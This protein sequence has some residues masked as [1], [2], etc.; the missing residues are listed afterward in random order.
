MAQI[1]DGALGE[2]AARAGLLAKWEHADGSSRSVTPDTLRAALRA[3]RLPCDTEEDRRE[4]LKRL[5]VQQE[6]S[7]R[8]LDV[9]DALPQAG[10]LTLETGEIRAAAAGDAIDVPGYHHL[11][12]ADRM[13]LLAVAPAA[14]PGVFHLTESRRAWGPAVQIY[15]LRGSCESGFGDLAALSLF[16]R[17]AA[18]SGAHLAAI[19]PVHALFMADPARCSPYAPS[20]RDMLNPLYA[21]PLEGSEAGSGDLIDWP[22]AAAARIARLEADFAAFGGDP[23]FDW[24]AAD[25]AVADH[26]LFEALSQHFVQQGLSA[27]WSGW[28]APFQHPDDVEVRRFAI[29]HSDAVRFHVYLQWRA[30]EGLRNVQAE[31]RTAGMGIGLVADLAVGLHP[32]GSH[33][34]SRRDELLDGLTIGAPPDIF[35]ADGQ[36]WGITSFSPTALAESGFDPFLR[37]VRKALGFAGGVRVD[38]ALGLERLWLIPQGAEPRDGV[39]LK[40]PFDDLVRLLVLEAHRHRALLIAE[41]LG[42]VPAGFRDRMQARHLLGMRVTTFERDAQGGFVD[43]ADWTPA[44]VAMTSTHDLIPIA[45]WWAGTDIG[46]RERLGRTSE[47]EDDRAADRA[48]FWPDPDRPA[49]DEPEPVVDKAIDD[50]GRAACEIA[51]VPIEDLIGQT[52]APNMPGTIDEHPNWRRRLPQADILSDPAAARRAAVLSKERPR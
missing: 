48:R 12:T 1:S 52:E 36:G 17:S 35:Q 43:P 39:Y 15:S 44:A 23:A 6:R 4:S 24:F 9:G 3:L 20:N 5:A 40:Q 13:I 16:V 31:A 11:E 38:H 30:S 46:W 2:L 10:R 50:V 28:P 42:T 51:I 22:S 34:W 37:T 27:D 45:G 19:N 29:T 25:P 21:A 26:A 41:D 7:F 33:S 8:T 47:S 18:R 14:A 49:P 32:H